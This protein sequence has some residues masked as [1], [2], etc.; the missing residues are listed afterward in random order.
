MASKINSLCLDM[1]LSPASA[2]CVFS[3][4]YP[5]CL[6]VSV[7]GTAVLYTEVASWLRGSGRMLSMGVCPLSLPL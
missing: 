5:P 3:S 6:C 7:P 4:P 1:L 2:W